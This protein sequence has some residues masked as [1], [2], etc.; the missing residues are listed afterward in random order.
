MGTVFNCLLLMLFGVTY[1]LLWLFLSLIGGYYSGKREQLGNPFCY[2]L[3][4]LGSFLIKKDSCV[5]IYINLPDNKE[6]IFSVLSSN[7]IN[8]TH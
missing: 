3:D 7:Y 4:N 1:W 8:A 2:I 5:I 6:C